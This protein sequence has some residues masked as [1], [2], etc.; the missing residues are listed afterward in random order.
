MYPQGL[1][2]PSESPGPVGVV[3]LL[4]PDRRGV[5][6]QASSG[7]SIRTS[8]R[9]AAGEREK[10]SS[11]K[12][13][14]GQEEL[15]IWMMLANLER[16][17]SRTKE[18]LGALLLEKITEGKAEASGSLGARPVRRQNSLLWSSGPGHFQPHGPPVAGCCCC[19]FPLHR[20]W[21]KPWSNWPG[22]R[23]IG[24]GIFRRTTGNACPDGSNNSLRGSAL[25]DSLRTGD[26]P[27]ERRATGDLRRVPAPG[28]DLIGLTQTQ[29]RS[30]IMTT[31]SLHPWT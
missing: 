10:E 8:S 21:L 24:K 20:P 12:A 4:A 6:P 29:S 28:P 17:P 15:E 7:R 25:R 11:V 2:F 1:Q 30:S 22:A 5:S 18:E 9:A 14:R 3:D 27:E 23:A 26:I 13:W 16:L 19:R 31:S